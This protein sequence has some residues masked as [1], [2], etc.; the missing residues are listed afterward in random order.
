[1]ALDVI[2]NPVFLPLLRLIGPLWFIVVICFIISLLVTFAY[3]WLTNQEMMK[4]LKED[5]KKHQQE[6]K[7]HKDNPK[8]MM[9]IQK[10]AMDKNLK[11]MTSSMKP[12]L[13][14]LLPLLLIF[15]WLNSH[16]S[17]EPLQPGRTFTV[18]AH[19]VEGVSGDAYLTVPE[20][21]TLTNNATQTIKDSQA[22]WKMKGKTGEY[23]LEV[24]YED[25]SFTKEVLIQ[26]ENGYKEPIKTFKDSVVKA[27]EVS[28]EKIV[29]L[30]LF[31]WKMGWLGAYIIFSLIFSMA[32]RKV[33]KIY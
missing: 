15:G 21:I 32:L 25:N 3:K 27:V 5:I 24:K 17:Y 12:S 20:G 14:T 19:F 16:M 1:M 10:M 2:F 29:V 6:I 30:N 8:K 18:T 28:H 23:L 13:I 26:K 22:V 4:S 33:M 9:E 31:G 11:Y 7:K